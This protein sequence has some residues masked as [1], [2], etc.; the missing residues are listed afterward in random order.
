[1]TIEY[2][3]VYSAIVVNNTNHTLPPRISFVSLGCAKNLVDTEKMLGVLGLAGFV[4]VGPGQEAEVTIV[5]TCGFIA[6]AREEAR[7]FI[8][9]AIEEKR[10]GN[11]G[12][13][14]VTGCLAQMWG[15][16]LIHEMP[17]IDAVVGLN[18]RDN[19]AEIISKAIES[20]GDNEGESQSVWGKGE[21]RAVANDHAR[22]RITSRDWSYLRISEG[23]DRKCTFCTIP[24]IRGPFR[25]KRVDEIISEAAELI[26]DGAVELNLI[27]QETSGYGVDLGYK[28]GLAGLLGELEQLE[29]LKWVRVLYMHPA[30]L[31][32]ELIEAM[33]RF[34]KVVPYVD[35]PLQHI[36]DR[37]LKLM[38][39]KI[40]RKRT[41]ELINKFR[42]KV[43]NVT[44]R[45]TMLVGFPT[46]TDEEFAELMDFVRA[47][48]FEALGG[49][50]YSAEEGTGAGGLGGQVSDAVKSQRLEE[51]MLCQQEIAFEHGSEYVGREL[52]CL[53]TDMVSESEVDQLELDPARQWFIG[54]HEGQGPEV[55]GQC[56]L[57]AAM[58][59]EIETGN[60]MAVTITA[61][62]GY[63]LIG[64]IE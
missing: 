31:D 3:S 36:N 38:N 10:R 16:K 17:Q 44:I 12:C 53:I 32:N 58:D 29:G 47:T 50:M 51:L 45:T 34:E 62:N 59:T 52:D 19:I 55:D 33:A 14:V 24:S 60:I 28:A 21:F 43:D 9:Q 30:T 40:T 18:Q 54:R 57:S 1:M 2:L 39:R 41:E 48:R 13:V 61:C 64:D 5:N 35:L 49:F 63:D 6:D 20:K 37:I 56:Y 22:L 25:S 4:L 15:E 11:V 23:C 26:A 8:A 46:E 7:D 42:E 27:G